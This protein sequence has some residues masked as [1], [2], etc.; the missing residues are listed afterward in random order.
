[1]AVDALLAALARSGTVLTRAELERIVETNDKKRF[2]FNAD[3]SLIRA[4]QGHSTPV[5]LGHPAAV[6]PELLYHG[7]VERFLADIL[8]EG[9]KPG[10]RHDVHLSPD[11]ATARRVGARRGQPVILIIQ[12]G[13]MHRDGHVFQLSDNGV[14]LTPHVPPRYI[15]R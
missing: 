9:M 10:A 7:T 5:T 6:P 4:V 12:A 15:R 13:E 8:R 3:L 11:E 14:W 1:V 2:A